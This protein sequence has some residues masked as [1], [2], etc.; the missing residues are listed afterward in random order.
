ME[1]NGT[2]KIGLVTPYPGSPV[3]G[4]ML[5]SYPNQH[6]FDINLTLSCHTR[7]QGF[8]VFLLL[9]WTSCCKASHL[10]VASLTKEVNP[11]LA[12]RPLETNGR[13]AILEL[14]SLVKETTGDLRCS[15]DISVMYTSC[16]SWQ[17]FYLCPLSPPWQSYADPTSAQ[18]QNLWLNY[19]PDQ[20][21]SS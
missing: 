20:P 6:W 4:C 19:L 9:A 14:T 10:S 3:V 16:E 1:N 13:L 12:K 11:G 18:S 2:E 15:Y 17:R 21:F 7:K 5:W 8:D